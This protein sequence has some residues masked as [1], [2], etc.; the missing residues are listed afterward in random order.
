[1]TEETLTEEQIRHKEMILKAVV[2][3]GLGLVDSWDFS[4]DRI[5]AQLGRF[6]VLEDDE[7]GLFEGTCGQLRCEVV[8]AAKYGNER[9][10][11]FFNEDGMDKDA[12]IEVPDMMML[13]P[14]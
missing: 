10:A 9:A 2:S 6:R 14:E 3:A 13:E 5:R 4:D 12:S 1:M 8:G 7:A 11:F